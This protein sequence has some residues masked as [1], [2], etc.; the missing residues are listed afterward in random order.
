MNLTFHRLKHEAFLATLSPCSLFRLAP[1]I[2]HLPMYP[3][4]F[5]NRCT[6]FPPTLMLFREGLKRRIINLC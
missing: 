3:A 2:E 1:Q 6:G 4:A 5:E